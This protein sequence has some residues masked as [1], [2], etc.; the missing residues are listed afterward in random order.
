MSELC[1]YQESDRSNYLCEAGAP[2][3]VLIAE[4]LFTENL[5]FLPY[6]RSIHNTP[7]KRDRHNHVRIERAR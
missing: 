3:A 2:K 5:C 7:I 6:K 4:E 1:V